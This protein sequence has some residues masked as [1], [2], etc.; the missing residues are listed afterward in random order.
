MQMIFF[1][2][3]VKS[4]KW[5]KDIFVKK[6]RIIDWESSKILKRKSCHDLDKFIFLYFMNSNIMK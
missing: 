5:E 6:L 2:L 4:M 3:K 1:E